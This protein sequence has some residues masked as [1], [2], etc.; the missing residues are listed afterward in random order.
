MTFTVPI[1]LQSWTRCQW[2]RGQTSPWR[3]GN[4][5]GRVVLQRWTLHVSD[6]VVDCSRSVWRGVRLHDAPSSRTRLANS[7]PMR[8]STASIDALHTARYGA[9]ADCQLT[10]CEF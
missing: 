8:S 7:E 1:F 3:R 4:P 10:G 6:F 5:H 9:R 2:V